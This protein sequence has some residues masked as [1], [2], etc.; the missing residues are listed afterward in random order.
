MSRVAALLLGPLAGLL[1]LFAAA[2]PGR[3]QDLDVEKTPVLLQAEELTYNED[4]GVVTARGNVE[5]SQGPRVLMAD[6]V[7]YNQK[8]NTV[9]ASGNV[10]LM[11]PTGEVLFT[12]YAELHDELKTGF[13]ENL[14][15]LLSDG[16]RLA[17]NRARRTADQ[18]K[19][20]D[21]GVFSPC[22]LC[23]EDPAR[24]P[25]WQ[26]KAIKVVHDEVAKDIIYEDAT[27]EMFGVPVLYTPYMRHPDPTV[28]RR[29]GLLAPTIGY[30]GDLGAIFGQPYY[31][32]FD[33]SRDVTIEPM[34]FSSEGTVL[35]GQYRQR[36]S[37]GRIDLKATAAYVDEHDDNGN[38]TGNQGL[39]GSADL[40]G[41]FALDRTW[42]GGFDFQQS[43]ERTYLKRFRLG[44]EDVLT[45]R[46]YA[47]GFRG[48]NY[49]AVNAYKWQDL[50]ASSDPDDT[51]LVMPF[52]EY[53]FVGQPNGL[54]G[55]SSIDAS[56]LA[57]TRERGTDSRRAS[58]VYGWKMPHTTGNGQL[59]TLE[60]RVQTD[61]YYA[62]DLSG[63]TGG[64][65][66]TTARL[67]PQVGVKWQY[68]WARRAATY[69]HVVEPIVGIVGGPNGGN[70]D[71]IPNEDSRSFEFD[72][73][74]L[75]R[76]NRYEGVDRVTSGSRVDYALRTGVYGDNGGSTELLIGQ[77][78]R[79]YG[80]SAFD[81]GTGLDEDLSDIVGALTVRPREQFDLS[82]RFRLDK[83][84]GSVRRNEFGFGYHH[85][86]FAALIDY[87][88]IDDSAAS[89][90]AG[91]REQVEATLNVALAPHWSTL[92][93]A[94]YD[95]S[96]GDNRLLRGRA[97]FTYSDECLTF[98]VDLERSD[99]EDQDIEADTRVMFRIV[100]KYL[101]GVESQ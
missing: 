65:D 93:N 56:L 90:L 24:A 100:F 60:S 21:R 89:D 58:L 61:G 43:S 95:L 15:A 78:Y 23:K 68:P 86:R 46:L 1:L 53:S 33:P 3:A 84:T 41:R 30:S 16:S 7:T 38:E 62:S 94:V 26:I 79:F 5:M 66:E 88:A 91:N 27:L 97:G 35:R 52:A 32:V 17:A 76:M 51:P 70:P 18:R 20:M 92:F 12:D 6:T 71:E 74:N 22:N 9:T 4:L 29:S 75:F 37:S 10:A 81:A 42:R 77:S 63:A 87:I 50:R 64:D 34:V 80:N 49:A 40:E 83:E 14:R 8:A 72:T 44:H 11:E 67:F 85:P 36:F 28:E 31:Y 47:E 45:S 57:L 59:L 69:T 48:R 82:Y 19:V 39:E 101:G 2:L 99:I 54:G 13:I 98:G 73:T 96:D 55:R 25:L